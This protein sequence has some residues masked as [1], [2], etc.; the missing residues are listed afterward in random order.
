MQENNQ[1]NIMENILRGRLKYLPK[2]K[3]KVVN[4]F[5]SS[6]FSDMHTERDYLI[7]NIYPRLKDYCI[8]QY[9]LEFQV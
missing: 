4:I 1:L 2:K 3:S 6:T 9:G 5:L 8:S 7:E